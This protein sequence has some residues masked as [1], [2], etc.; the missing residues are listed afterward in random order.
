MATDTHVYGEI[1]NKT[2]LREVTKEIRDDVRNAKDRSA[3][4]EL[5]RRAG[6]LVTL[7]HAN[8]WKEKF[9]DEIDEIRSVAEE[10]FATTARTINRQAEEIGTDAN[11]DETWGEKK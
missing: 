7:S 9:G 8:S 6:Y 3:L 10:E 1:D 2:N 11:Y 5:Y 4:T